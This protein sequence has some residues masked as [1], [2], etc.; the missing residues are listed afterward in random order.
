[1]INCEKM[2]KIATIIYDLN[3]YSDVIQYPFFCDDEIQKVILAT[4]KYARDDDELY[5][6]SLQIQPIVQK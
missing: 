1:M 6:L 4:I 3:I 2:Q 5:D